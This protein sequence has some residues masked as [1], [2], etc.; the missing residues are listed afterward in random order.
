MVGVIVISE[1]KSAPELLKTVQR[2]LGQKRLPGIE[3]LVIKSSHEQRTLQT[4]LNK[5]IKKIGADKGILI[6]NELYGSTQCNICKDF[7]SAN[8]IELVTGYNLPMLIR[9]ATNNQKA[10]LRDLAKMAV[11]AGQKYIKRF[12]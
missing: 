5:A 7:I 11:D 12:S 10:S 9:V 2:V 4:K 1:S 3:S 6:L 8:S